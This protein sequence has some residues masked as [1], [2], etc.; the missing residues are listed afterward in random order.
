MC[1]RLLSLTVLIVSLALE[2]QAQDYTKLLYR[3][4]GSKGG[5]IEQ[6]DLTPMPVFNPGEA[7]LTLV[8]QLNRPV[9]KY[10][11]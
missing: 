4:C 1:V 3:D 11:V 8:A 2:S 10:R 7:Y 6:I 5:V 9:S